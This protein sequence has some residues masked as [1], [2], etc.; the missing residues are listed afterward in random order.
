MKAPPVI[1]SNIKAEDLKQEN[2]EDDDFRST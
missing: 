2:D 1:Q